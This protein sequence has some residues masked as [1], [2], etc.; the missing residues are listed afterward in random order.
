MVWDMTMLGSVR[1]DYLDSAGNY[2][3]VLRDVA[4][5]NVADGY[6]GDPEFAVAHVMDAT[7]MPPNLS[8]RYRE[9]QSALSVPPGRE[10]ANKD[11]K[12][13]VADNG[14]GEA[15]AQT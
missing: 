8:P 11:I 12:K 9:T 7:K 3:F 2:D 1:V 10:G 5:G 6:N 4:S 15:K 14:T 13:R